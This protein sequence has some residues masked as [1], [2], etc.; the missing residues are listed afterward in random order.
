M[1]LELSWWKKIIGFNPHAVIKPYKLSIDKEILQN[2]DL[3]NLS[4]NFQFTNSGE[5]V[6]IN[7]N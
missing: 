3:I 7:K 1:V 6:L 5:A 2:I 4:T